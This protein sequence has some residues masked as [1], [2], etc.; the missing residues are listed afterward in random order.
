MCGAA[1]SMP[2]AA[3]IGRS[4]ELMMSKRHFIGK[5]LKFYIKQ[6]GHLFIFHMIA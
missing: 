3:D 5:H 4:K 2:E 6:S 1:E